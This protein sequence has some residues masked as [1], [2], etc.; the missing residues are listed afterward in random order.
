MKHPPLHLHHGTPYDL[1]HLSPCLV[2][3]LIKE[4]GNYPEI[5]LEM[6]VKYTN[7]CY[8]EGKP[9]IAGA[10]SDLT[11]HHN[12]PRWFCPYRHE[13]SLLLP[14]LITNLPD[15]KCLFT[16]KTNWL[17]IELLGRNGIQTPFHVYF[18][19]KKKKTAIK[20]SLS[21]FIESA[22]M[23]DTGDNS[24][25]RRGSLDRIRFAMLARKTIAGESVRR[26]P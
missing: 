2:S 24:P 16:G 19:L 22:Y 14:Q 10:P 9:K 1:R 13:T 25:K 20:N 15:R 3:M 21:L 11:D 17:V 4:D 8:S 7:H 6:D 18:T 23:K 26:P 5:Q 12:Q